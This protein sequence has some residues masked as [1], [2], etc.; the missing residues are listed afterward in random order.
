MPEKL[1]TEVHVKEKKGSIRYKLEWKWSTLEQY[2][3]HSQESVEQWRGS[4]KATKKRMSALFRELKE[5]TAQGELPE[6]RT[7]YEFVDVVKAF[8]ELADPEWGEALQEFLDHLSVLISAVEEGRN[9]AA[10]HEIRDLGSRM[11]AC[12]REF[13]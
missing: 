3:K 12:H 4:L 11:S 10:L 8:S 9:E 5:A 1:H 6:K 2:E 7:L 13:K